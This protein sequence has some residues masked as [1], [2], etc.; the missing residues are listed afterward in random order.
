MEPR[1]DFSQQILRG[2]DVHL[3]HP[4]RVVVV[5]LSD[6]H[7]YDVDK[8]NGGNFSDLIISLTVLSRAHEGPPRRCCVGREAAQHRRE[9]TDKQVRLMA[10]GAAQQSGLGR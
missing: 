6:N 1:P 7:V 9:E 5:T 8:I 3:H 4:R 2:S 10:E